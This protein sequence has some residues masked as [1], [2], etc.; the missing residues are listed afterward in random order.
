MLCFSYNPD[1]SSEKSTSHRTETVGVYLINSL[2]SNEIWCQVM[3]STENKQTCRWI[4]LH[5]PG[6]IF[7]LFYFITTFFLHS[8]KMVLSIFLGIVIEFEMLV[9]WQPY[10]VHQGT[11]VLW[12]I[13]GKKINL[14]T[15][16]KWQSSCFPSFP[17]YKSQRWSEQRC[18]TLTTG[19]STEK[20]A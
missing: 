10:T 18:F 14:L 17:V 16:P 15:D 20:T 9:S 8:I 19:V 2:I 1:W 6:F 11:W 13:Y 5:G 4:H 7:L 3:R 12:P